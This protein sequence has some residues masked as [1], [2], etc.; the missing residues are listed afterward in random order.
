MHLKHRLVDVHS[1]RVFA[2]ESDGWLVYDG[3]LNVAPVL[4]GAGCV[5]SKIRAS[6][7]ER[8]QQPTPFFKPLLDLQLSQNLPL[9]QLACLHVRTLCCCL[10]SSQ[11]HQT[12]SVYA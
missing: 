1:L 11:E 4:A 7:P 8:P 6:H 9:V 3:M 5:A 2:R 12:G 10:A